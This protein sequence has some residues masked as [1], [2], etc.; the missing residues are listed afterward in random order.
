MISNCGHDENGKYAGGKAGDQT[1]EEYKNIG[2]Y[3]RPWS[4]VLRHPSMVVGNK[5]AEISRMAADNDNVGYDQNDRL[6]YYN[7]LKVAQW[8]P[9]KIT[10][11]CNGDCSATTSANI[12]AAGMILDIGPLKNI[13][14]SNTTKSL[15]AT[16]IRAGFEL[17]TD[18]KYL[19]S[20]KYLL[21]GDIL[22]YDGHHVVVNLDKGSKANT[23]D[24]FYTVG[25]N[26]DESGWWYADTKTTFLHSGFKKIVESWYYFNDDGYAYQNQW[27]QAETENV[28][29]KRWFYFDNDCKMVTGFYVVNGEPFF[30]NKDGAMWEGEI[31]LTFTTNER[32]ALT[33]KKVKE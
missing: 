31:S 32:G 4:C 11:Q 22:L 17:L 1:K 21:P 27:V 30:F 6:S 15:R 13:S 18:Q 24:K 26:K 19:T 14:P 10:K 2:W 25:W 7:L 3:N 9:S 29:G 23:T 20:D 12:I 28:K 8:N 5:I 33:F 16:L